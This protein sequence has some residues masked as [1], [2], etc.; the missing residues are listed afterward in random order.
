M[1]VFELGSSTFSK[2]KI[3]PA[4][5]YALTKNAFFS[6]CFKMNQSRVRLDSRLQ[7]CQDAHWKRSF[8]DLDYAFF[9]YDI[10]KGYPLASGH[11]PGFTHPIFLS[12]YESGKQT[13]DCRYSVPKGL[14]VVPDVSCVTSF[15]SKVIRNRLEMSKSLQAAANVEGV[16]PSEY[17]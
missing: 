5:I 16:S 9:G 8:P 2:L 15:S 4:S 3:V 7:D 6:S 12:D 11:D 14:V 13:S 1:R 10:L 17:Y